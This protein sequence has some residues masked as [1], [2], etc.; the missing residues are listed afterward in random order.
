[1]FFSRKVLKFVHALIFWFPFQVQ[2]ISFVKREENSTIE[3]QKC[4]RHESFPVE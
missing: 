1:M 2:F 4:K 3:Q